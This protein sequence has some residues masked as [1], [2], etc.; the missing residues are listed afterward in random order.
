MSMLLHISGKECLINAID[1]E[2]DKCGS[3]PCHEH[4]TNFPSQ[5]VLKLDTLVEIYARNYDLH[6]CLVTGANGNQS[7][8]QNR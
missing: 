6:D 5:L 7:I 2:E 8:H 1:E 4:T 3:V